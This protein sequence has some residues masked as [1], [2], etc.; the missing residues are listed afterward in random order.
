MTMTSTA[1]GPDNAQ[2]TINTYV[3]GLGSK[4]GHDL[5]LV[6]TRWHGTADIDRADPAASSVRVSVE[7]SS[8][9]VL[10]ATGGLKP[11]SAGDKEDI[12]ENRDK[13]LSASKHPTIDF[14]STSAS[15]DALTG[16]LTIAGKTRPVTLALT[17]DG[18]QVTGTTS[19]LQ[20]D[21]GVKPYSKL[22]A[23]KVKD[24]IDLTVVL[25]LP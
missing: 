2:L 13:T 22:G 1:I 17:V 4:L 18:D 25:T 21:F 12:A 11:L 16:D 24:E 5:V 3:G 23:L 9:D 15:A 19:F 10:K 6:A 8:L 14:A 20:T 7:V